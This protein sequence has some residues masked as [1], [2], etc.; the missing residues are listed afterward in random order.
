MLLQVEHTLILQQL[1]LEPT[2][3]Q[4]TDMPPL[5]RISYYAYMWTG[6]PLV[7]TC[8]I[9]AFEYGAGKG[10]WGESQ[11]SYCPTETFSCT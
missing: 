10:E 4:K 6:M 5:F 1:K 11:D 2:T 8:P 9:T 3:T 7:K